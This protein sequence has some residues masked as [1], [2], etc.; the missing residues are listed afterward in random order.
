MPKTR[1]QL[2]EEAERLLLDGIP[3]SQKQVFDAIT[4][5]LT[6][7]DR[8]QGKIVFNSETTR[9]INEASK[10]IYKA[11]NQAGYDS[12]VKQYLKDFNKIKEATI[13][14]QKILNRITVSPRNLTNIQRS[15]IQQTTNIL[16][17]NGL[18][19]NLVQPVKDVLLRSA[20][21]GM[22]IA[23][24]EL[25]LRETILGNPERLGKLGRYV[26]QIS[27]DS[28][29]QYDGMMQERIAKD[30]DLDG[31][32]YEGSIIKD[33]REQCIRW[34]G[35]GEIPVADLAKEIDWAYANGSGMIPGTTKDN[36]MIYKGGY[37]C[38]HS[39]TAIRL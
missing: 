38:R 6:E 29:S 27:R 19:A 30:Y 17:G 35:M 14:E 5:L 36:F 12:R 11:L 32:S 13:A 25:Q 20:T 22:T 4:K 24:A 16:L 39:C 18:D 21:S 8:T 28:I 15:A 37:S 34:A 31:V 10:R 3:R 2:I 33:S 23:Q 7:F 1:E 26:T 9:L